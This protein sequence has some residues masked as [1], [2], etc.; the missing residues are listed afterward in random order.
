[1]FARRREK[2]VAEITAAVVEQLKQQQV[3]ATPTQLDVVGKF[4]ESTLGGMGSFMNGASE[5]A[6][7][8]SAAL[9][10]QRGGWA[11]A[12]NRRA[13]QSAAAATVESDCELCIDPMSRNLTVPIILEHNAKHQNRRPTD[14]GKRAAAPGNEPTREPSTEGST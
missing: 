6:L 2:L 13:K 14:P 8:S 7:R 9:M 3:G 11:K 1:M 4:F 12:K 10:G 5:L